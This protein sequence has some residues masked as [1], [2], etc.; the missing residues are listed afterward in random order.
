MDDSGRIFK[1]KHFRKIEV[2]LTEEV[3]AVIPYGYGGGIEFFI[4]LIAIGISMVAQYKV[5][6]T[7]DKYSRQRSRLGI[8]GYDAARRILNKNN[9]GNIPIEIVPGKLSDHY[10]PRSRVL[11]LSG[12]VYHGTSLSSIG[13]AAHEVGHAIQHANSYA[14][15]GFRNLM[16]P[17]VAFSSKFV[18]V[19][20]LAGLFLSIPSLIDLGI[21]FFLV[22]L[23]FQLITLPVEFNASKRAISSLKDGII[24]EDEVGPV[25][26]VLG[27]A[28]MT[29]LAAVLVSV[30]QLLRLL[31]LRKRD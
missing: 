19:L 29:Y 20:I 14:P 15:L 3:I 7:F 12:E 4:F 10:D 28:A 9:L 6:S 30:A 5:Q 8:T 23:A 21:L 16:A 18:F 22:V 24:T 25:K 1:R 26:K 11:R 31:G 17:A 2:K 13:V 27:A